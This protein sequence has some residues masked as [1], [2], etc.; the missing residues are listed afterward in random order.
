MANG[1]AHA[2]VT[3]NQ[4]I[5]NLS[6]ESESVSGTNVESDN[7]TLGEAVSNQPE[8]MNIIENV[9]PKA[10]NSEAS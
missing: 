7:V 1:D 2:S 5:Q 8:G 6:V 9:E 3:K 10:D 4:E